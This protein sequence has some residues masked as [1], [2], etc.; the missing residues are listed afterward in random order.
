M[1]SLEKAADKLRLTKYEVT[2]LGLEDENGNITKETLKSYL[3]ETP[4]KLDEIDSEE[5]KDIQEDHKTLSISDLSEKYRRHPTTLSQ[6][7]DEDVSP[8]IKY[9]EC[10]NFGNFEGNYGGYKEKGKHLTKEDE[11]KLFHAYNYWKYMSI[12]NPDFA[13]NAKSVCG[14]LVKKYR[15]LAFSFIRKFYFLGM[16][17]LEAESLHY[18]L[19]NINNFDYNLGVKFSTFN[20]HCMQGQFTRYAAKRG[21]TGVECQVK[22]IESM[23]GCVTPDL[24]LQEDISNIF[25]AIRPNYEQIIRQKF[26]IGCV[27]KSTKELAKDAG[28]SLSAINRTYGLALKEFRREVLSRGYSM[29]DFLIQ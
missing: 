2:R 7:L 12:K 21:K 24:D 11:A 19:V 1:I 6:I 13:R 15:K 25:K 26:G 8:V 4:Y 16:E 10:E 20:W 3:E 9:I 27:A 17:E 23:V 28:V 22:D 29:E 5:Y 14:I 18:L